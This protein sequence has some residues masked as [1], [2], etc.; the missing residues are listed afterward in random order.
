MADSTLLYC[1]KHG[2]DEKG[3]KLGK[4]YDI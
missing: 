1:N 3:R 2:F 4:I